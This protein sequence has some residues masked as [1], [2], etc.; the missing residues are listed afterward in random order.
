M[1]TSSNASRRRAQKHQNTFAFKTGLYGLTPQQK[2]VQNLSIEGV[3]TR[4]KDV[5]EWKIK[6]DK[7]KPLTV[8]ARCTKCGEKNI[9]KAYHMLCS[10]C[11]GSSDLCPKCGK[12][13]PLKPDESE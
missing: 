11:A 9:K 8:P 6:Y 7:Y 4:C 13:P 3:C 1:S 10:G 2:A 5:L 12:V